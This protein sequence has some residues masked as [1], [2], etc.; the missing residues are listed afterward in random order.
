MSYLDPQ[1]TAQQ[2]EQQARSRRDRSERRH[3]DQQPPQQR[4]SVTSPNTESTLA[5]M[6]DNNNDNP[7]PQH[8]PVGDQQHGQPAARLGQQVED[9]IDMPQVH[10]RYAPLITEVTR[11]QTPIDKEMILREWLTRSRQV[12][13]HNGWNE[14]RIV[15]FIQFCTVSDYET[16]RRVDAHLTEQEFDVVSALIASRSLPFF[17]AARGGRGDGAPRGGRGG[18]RGGR[19]R[20]RGQDGTS[21]YASDSPSYPQKGL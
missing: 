7:P 15:R 8:P 17:A 3:Q 12:L 16:L 11:A 6:G 21:S 10:V 14:A 1:H 13:T 20:G 2:I 9:R 19:G 18:G 5:T 4:K